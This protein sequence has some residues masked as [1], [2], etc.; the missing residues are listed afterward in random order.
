MSATFAGLVSEL[1]AGF[2]R[3]LQA[4]QLEA[5]Q[6]AWKQ[7]QEGLD[8]RLCLYHR[9]GAGKTLT[10]LACVRAAGERSAVVVAPPVTHEAWVRTG[11]LVGVTVQPISHAIFRSPKWRIDRDKALIVDEFHLL[12]GHGKAGFTKLDR[13][14]KGLRAPLVV[15]SATPNYNDAERCYCIMHV[16]DP[17]R[18]R[19]GY[20]NFLYRECIT[21]VNPFGKLPLVDGFRN[22]ADAEDYLRNQPHVHYV[23]DEA[24]KQVTIED[25]WVSVPVPESL[26]HYMVDHRKQRMI[27]SLMELRHRISDYQILQD[28]GGLGTETRA[29]IERL[30]EELGG[31]PLLIFCARAKYAEAV[32]RWLCDQRRSSELVTGKLSTLLKQRRVERFRNGAVNIL[33]GTSTLATGTDGIDKMCDTLLIVDDTDDD[34][35]RRQLMGRILPR[36]LD[37]DLSKKRVIRLLYG[38][39]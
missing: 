22:Y 36:G 37:T 18:F 23:E 5:A 7:A 17:L 30:L 6:D 28:D 13:I 4:H 11:Q 39:H 16:L 32:H 38:N 3:P 19:G 21:R 26:T 29:E 24:I 10:A 34:A 2:G 31:A 35:L 27:A 9:T 1:E 14:A 8:P 20:E 33:I 25:R 15:A 12:G